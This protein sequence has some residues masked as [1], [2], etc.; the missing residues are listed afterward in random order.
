MVFPPVV[1]VFQLIGAVMI[2]FIK[3]DV[4]SSK[5]KEDEKCPDGGSGQD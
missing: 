2:G 1:K 5:K 4:N 3:L